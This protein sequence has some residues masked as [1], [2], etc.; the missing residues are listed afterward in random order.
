[1]R[2]YYYYT[3]DNSRQRRHS[4]VNIIPNSSAVDN[5]P[6]DDKFCPRCS[7]SLIW[8]DD[9]ISWQCPR[10]GW[11]PS[12]AI[13]ERRPS[14]SLLLS[15][16]SSLSPPTASPPVNNNKDNAPVLRT[17]KHGNPDGSS[18]N[19]LNIMPVP[20]KRSET[21]RRMKKR[22]FPAYDAD[23]KLLESRGYTLV[24]SQETIPN[25]RDTISSDEL[26]DET[27]R[28]RSRRRGVGRSW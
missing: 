4:D 27:Q 19:N 12:Y 16:L 8:R 13:R 24:N 25:S 7:V 1:M 20:S 26:R 11:L 2:D 9:L 6:D 15:S 22:Q 18:S 14:S 10:C 17:S 5:S 23:S 3:G 21:E 28:T